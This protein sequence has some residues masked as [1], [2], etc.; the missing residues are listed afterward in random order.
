MR[1]L[2]KDTDP[3]FR[4]DVDKGTPVIYR[5]LDLA[6]PPLRLPLGMDS[7]EQAKDKVRHMS[8][9]IKEY[10]SWAKGLTVDD[11]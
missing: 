11:P 7:I 5:L 10:E 8:E 2:W 1:E 3:W 6:K 9:E 4:G